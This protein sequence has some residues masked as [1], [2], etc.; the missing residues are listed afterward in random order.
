MARGQ[1]T[2]QKELTPEERMQ[3][4]LVPR[5][6]WPYELP[7]GWKWVTLGRL[8]DVIGG[9]T[10]STRHPEYYEGGTIPW[11][12][13]ADLSGYSEMY[14]SKGQKNITQD[15]LDNSSARLLPKETVCLSSRA[16]IGYVVIAQNPLCTNQGFKSFTPSEYIYPEFLYWYLKANKPMLESMA[17]GTTFL[18]LSGKKAGQIMMPLPSVEIQK[19]ISS[20][21]DR[22]FNRLDEAKDQIQSVLDSSEERKQSILHRAFTGEL[23]EKWRRAH[24]HSINEWKTITLDECGEWYGGGTPSK[25]HPEYWDNADLLWITSKDMKTDLI[26]DTQIKINQSGVDGSSAKL[27][28]NPA[29]LFVM[30]SGI[31]RHTAPIAMVKTRFTVNQDLKALVIRKDILLEYVFYACREKEHEILNTCMKNG[32]TVESLEFDKLKKLQI[33]VPSTEEQKEIVRLLNSFIAKEDEVED[34]SDQIMSSVEDNKKAILSKA[35]RGEYI[36][37]NRRQTPDRTDKCRP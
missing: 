4:A 3:S 33:R 20:F 14:I 37:E 21:V 11:L 29:I 2:K 31:L 24:N 34:A 6:E 8:T 13:P 28:E 10:P 27:I 35:F 7:E 26:E 16:P 32:T 17:S 36:Y 5:E 18:E 12:S 1:K 25:S 19:S 23:T 9:G 30:R 22:E 15:G